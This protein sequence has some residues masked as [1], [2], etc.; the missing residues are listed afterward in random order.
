MAARTSGWCFLSR[1]LLGFDVPAVRR[2]LNELILDG[3]HR[4]L[5][6]RREDPA[7][8][9]SRIVPGR[10]GAR[11]LGRRFIG[12]RL[13]LIEKY[14]TEPFLVRDLRRPYFRD[15]PRE[16]AEKMETRLEGPIDRGAKSGLERFI[17]V[18]L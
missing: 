9:R 13:G 6:I 16:R 3:G 4:V 8:G 5:G 12:D 7:V 1:L 18:D 14:F 11:R 15:F 10:C 2:R 17:R